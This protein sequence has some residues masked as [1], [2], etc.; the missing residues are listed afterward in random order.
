MTTSRTIVKTLIGV[1]VAVT[2]AAVLV[3]YF[4][5]GYHGRLFEECRAQSRALL[6]QTPTIARVEAELGE[7]PIR[8]AQPADASTVARIWT[9]ALNS[10]DEIE[11]K[12]SKWPETR[13][14]RARAPAMMLFIYFDSQGIM[15]DFSCAEG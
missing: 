8:T 12:V 5:E 11:S 2:V 10:L 3:F 9:H 1:C 7:E 13:I 4:V 6:S 14:Y 15:R